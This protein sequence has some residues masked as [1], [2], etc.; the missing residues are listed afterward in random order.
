MLSNPVERFFA[1]WAT[2]E[3]YL[4]FRANDFE[5]QKVS[6]YRIR[7]VP[8]LTK[9]TIRCKVYKLTGII[10]LFYVQFT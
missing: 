6:D 9:H 7:F 2:F 10:L 4:T 1:L 3:Q 8:R 5:Q